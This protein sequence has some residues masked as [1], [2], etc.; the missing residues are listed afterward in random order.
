MIQFL[1]YQTGEYVPAGRAVATVNDPQEL[2]AKIYV[3][4]ARLSEVSLGQQVRF[5][6][7]AAPGQEF[8]GSVVF[9]ASEAEFTP[10]NVQT[11][12]ERINLVFA[13]KVSVNPGQPGLRPGMP[14]D[15]YFN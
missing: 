3:P 1:P 5:Q 6:I 14:A 15:F 11:P 4:E 12:D 2:W 7:D 8:T 13:V 9:I 10:R